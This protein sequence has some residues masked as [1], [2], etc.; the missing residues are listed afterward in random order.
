MMNLNE[1]YKK[2]LVLLL[3]VIYL[4]QKYIKIFF[5]ILF[6]S[7]HECYQYFNKYI[8]RNLNIKCYAKYGIH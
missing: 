5:F 1:I 7:W 3:N 8:L 6:K 2:N 4:V